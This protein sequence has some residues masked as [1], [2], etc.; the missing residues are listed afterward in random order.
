MLGDALNDAGLDQRKV[1][2]PTVS[3]SW[4]PEAIKEQLWRRIQKAMFEKK[5]T[6]NLV[7]QKSEKLKRYLQGTCRKKFGV[8]CPIWPYYEEGEYEEKTAGVDNSTAGDSA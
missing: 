2:K 4:T 1:L 3:I 8:E 6:T 5:S 7:K